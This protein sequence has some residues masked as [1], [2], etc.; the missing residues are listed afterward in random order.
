MRPLVEGKPRYDQPNVDF[1]L[2]Q[3]FRFFDMNVVHVQDFQ[4]FRVPFDKYLKRYFIGHYNP[5]GNHFFA[6]A[7]KDTLIDW[8]D[9]KPL[10]YQ[11]QAQREITFEKYLPK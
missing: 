5:A 10:T 1:L 2:E 3:R 8:L 7:I 11:N 6:Y 9:P 4:N